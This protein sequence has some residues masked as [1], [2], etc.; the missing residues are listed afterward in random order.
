MSKLARY[1]T[2]DIF[3]EFDRQMAEFFSPV[4]NTFYTGTFSPAT[5]VVVASDKVLIYM[6]APGMEED[7]ISI[8]TENRN[9][10]VKGERIK[11]VSEGDQFARSERLYGT[12]VRTFAV[13][14]FVDLNKISA[15][16]IRGVLTIELGRLEET[17]PKQITIG[18][19]EN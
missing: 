4:K 9:L 14:D 12:F 10:I 18:K 3:K 5:D 8:T 16:Y 7:N 13:P 6:D 11:V 19:I 1:S 17:K 15:S 2:N